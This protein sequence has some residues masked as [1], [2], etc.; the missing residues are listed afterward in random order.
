MKNYMKL[1][2]NILKNKNVV[3]SRNGE[4]YAN[5]GESLKFDL[6]KGFPLLTNKYINFDHILHE[7]I[8]YLK[9]T[10]K[11]TYLKENN[12]HIWNLWADDNDSIG[13]TYGV[14][15]RNFNGIDQVKQVVEDLK[16]NKYSRRIIING[17]NVNQLDEMALPPCL[18]LL[19]FNVDKNNKL[20]TVVYQRSGDFA[21]G[22][23]Y[24]I[25]EMALLTHILANI[26]DLKL[27]ELTMQYGNIHLYME[28]VDVFKKIQS[29]NKMYKLPKL[30]IKKKL[31]NIDN[32]NASDIVLKNYKHAPHIRYKIK[33]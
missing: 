21:I 16:T 29:K 33:E 1:G 27:G 14:Q 2:H 30:V 8:W 6:K 7:T 11:I 5:Y 9:G 20:H 13:P 10:D 32:I 22:V 3:S 12:I 28:H 19:Q 15:W 25:A 23:P 31:K 26:C 4:I 18:V 17:W 24:D